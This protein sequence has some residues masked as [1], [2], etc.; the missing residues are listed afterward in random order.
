MRLI[1]FQIKYIKFLKISFQLFGLGS[2]SIFYNKKSGTLK[3]KKSSRTI[4]YNIFLICALFVIWILNI[5]NIY[6]KTV[7]N[8][9]FNLITAVDILLVNFSSLSSILILTISTLKIKIF[10]RITSNLLNYY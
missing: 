3:F 9:S 4:V 7:F 2:V 10:I 8:N 6:I 5:R 1:D